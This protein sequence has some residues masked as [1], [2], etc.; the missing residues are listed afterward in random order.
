MYAA[1]LDKRDVMDLLLDQ[2]AELYFC[3]D[4][5]GGNR[6]ESAFLSGLAVAEKILDI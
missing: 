2:G 3:G 5:C 4:W 6:V 1:E